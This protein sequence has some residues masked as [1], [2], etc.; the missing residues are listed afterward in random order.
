MASESCLCVDELL[1]KLSLID[2]LSAKFDRE[3][4]KD[5]VDSVKLVEECR[6]LLSTVQLYID[7]NRALI[8][9]Y[10]LKTASNSLK[11]LE[12]RINDSGKS[13]L[14][15]KFSAKSSASKDSKPQKTQVT[16]TK[17]TKVEDSSKAQDIHQDFFGFQNRIGETLELKQGADVDLKDIKLVNLQDC[18]I[19][20]FGLA[21]T[22][23]IR[24]LKNCSVVVCLACRA[25]TITNSSDCFFKFICQQLRIDSTVKSVFHTYTSARAMLEASSELKFGPLDLNKVEGLTI[26]EIRELL[27]RAN[28]DESKNN[29]NCIDD[30][31]WLAPNCPSK[32]YSISSCER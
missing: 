31:D 15:F 17:P 12:T 9:S 30:F 25:I 24:G 21:S 26:E 6:Q 1:V 29:W 14:L 8:P 32:N 18:T 22:I 7:N 13:K 19:R 11:K 3:H 10:I 28:F 27:R 23:Y 20:I 16:Q 4:G 2:E 5:S